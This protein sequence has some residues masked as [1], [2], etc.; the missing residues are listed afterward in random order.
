MNRFLLILLV[1]LSIKI[2]AQVVYEPLFN[3][4]YGFLSSLSQKG[5]IEFNDQVKP[6][7]RIYLAQK[8]LE[9]EVQTGL[10]PLEKEDLEFYKKDFFNEINFLEDKHPEKTSNI[11]GKDPAGRLRL[12]SYAD[13]KFKLNI[14]PIFGVKAGVRDE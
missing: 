13:D 1:I 7:S 11:V 2:N 5:L 9:A 4:V 12:Y 8:L 6:L 10:T 14:S 3:D